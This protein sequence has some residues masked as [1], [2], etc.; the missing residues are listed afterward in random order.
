MRNQRTPTPQLFVSLEQQV[1]QRLQPGEDVLWRGQPDEAAY[2]RRSAR[3]FPFVFALLALPLAWWVSQ[4]PAHAQWAA[5]LTLLIPFATLGLVTYRSYRQA[6]LAARGMRYWITSQR[7]LI[8]R[9]QQA[10]DR[11][12]IEEAPL[13]A[14][15]FGLREHG[16]L[17]TVTIQSGQAGFP[18]ALLDLPDARDAYRVLLAVQGPVSAEPPRLMPDAPAELS[19]A[20]LRPGE[21]VLWEGGPDDAIMRRTAYRDAAII[22]LLMFSLIAVIIYYAPTGPGPSISS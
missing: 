4:L 9:W 5:G 19:D 17:G 11:W 13:S 22:F 3:W 2:A 16:R 8:H 21:S 14:L 15:R 12:A 20:W 1:R 10:Q 18:R 7:L 6:R